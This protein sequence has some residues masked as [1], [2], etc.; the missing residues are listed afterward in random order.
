MPA[1]VDEAVD[2]P[3]LPAHQQQRQARH[4]DGQRITGL[5]QRC[6]GAQRQRVLAKD[7]FHL[8]RKPCRVQVALHRAHGRLAALAAAGV[9]QRQCAPDQG[10]LFVLL[11]R[12][13]VVPLLPIPL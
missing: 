5:G 1:G 6:G 9:D 2:L 3:A 10:D 8:T 7:V 13:S 12:V 11:H 4:V